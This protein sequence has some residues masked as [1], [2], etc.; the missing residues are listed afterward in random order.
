MQAI[1]SHGAP[2]LNS[3]CL[4]PTT[5]HANL[6]DCSFDDDDDS[7]SALLIYMRAAGNA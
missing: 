6:R 2:H 5:T 1:L 4:K 7:P 3:A